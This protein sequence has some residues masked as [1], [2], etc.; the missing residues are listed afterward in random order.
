MKFLLIFVIFVAQYFIFFYQYFPSESLPCVC[1]NHLNEPVD[2]FI[3]YKLPRLPYSIDPF[4]ANGTGYIYLDSSS[5]V[6]QWHLSSES[7]TSS[8]SLTGLTLQ[9]LYNSKENSFMFYNDQPP[10]H[11]FSLIY[12]HSK[13]VLAFHDQTQTGFWLVHSVPHFP[14][15]IEQGYGYPDSGRV[16]GQTMLCITLNVS[17]ASIP[18]NSIDILS[19]HFLY[20]RPFVYAY[21]LTSFAS[22]RYSILANGIIPNKAHISEPPYTRS[23]S[24][25]ISSFEVLTFAK[26]G[27]ANIDMLS[28]LIVPSLRTTMLSETWSNGG[29]INLPS[30]CTGEYHTENIEKLSFNFTVHNDHSKWLVSENNTWTCIGDMNRQVEQIKRHGGFVCI[31]NKNIQQRF[32]QLVLII[33]SCSINKK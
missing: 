27:L 2:W 19:N 32:K 23:Y 5:S 18:L 9:S 22:E 25:N 10:N 28:E 15:T 20:T 16:F 30:N 13:G 8:L 14:S 1:R 6:D 11:P 33:E 17:A 7:I 24:L 12:G 26:Y 21:G 29:Q 31:N 3:V 4:I